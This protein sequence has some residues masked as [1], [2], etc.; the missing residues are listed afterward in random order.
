MPPYVLDTSAIMCVLFQ[1][2]GANQVTA[3]LEAAGKA[4]GKDH[5]HVL[6]PFMALMETEYW[7][8]RRLTSREVEHTRLLIESWPGT[9]WESSP[10]RRHGAARVKATTAPLSVADA[11]IASLAIL[12]DGELV[13]KDP[14]FDRV[15]GLKMLRLPYKARS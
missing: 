4:P 12:Q 13:H 11:W 2:A 1:E 10:E 8:M 6:L 7:L 9:V 15:N 14:E 5:L 3:I